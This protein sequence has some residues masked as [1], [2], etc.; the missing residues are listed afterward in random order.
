MAHERAERFFGDMVSHER[1]HKPYEKKTEPV[2]DEALLEVIWDAF[3]GRGKRA[4]KKN[5]TSQIANEYYIHPEDIYCV[6]WNEEIKKA[7][8]EVRC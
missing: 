6:D 2:V 7:L 8:E 3:N 1:I 4:S 5:K